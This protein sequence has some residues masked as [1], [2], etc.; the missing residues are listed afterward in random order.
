MNA[1]NQ[2]PRA[3]CGADPACLRDRE[4]AA[5]AKDVAEFGEAGHRDRRNPPLDQEVHVGVRAFAKFGWNHVRTEKRRANINGM[6][7]MQVR[8]KLEDFQLALPIEAVA[9]LGFDGGSAVSYEFAQVRDRAGFELTGG[10][11]T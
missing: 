7:L 9:A 6:A 5:I 10:R 3:P 8:K 4:R 11:A 1:W 2:A